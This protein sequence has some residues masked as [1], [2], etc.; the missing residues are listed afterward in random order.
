[1]TS[2]STVT[3]MLWQLPATKML[4]LTS[5]VTG[6]SHI[7]FS[8]QGDPIDTNFN[9]LHIDFNGRKTHCLHHML[10]QVEL[11]QRLEGVSR[12]VRHALLTTNC[13]SSP[14]QR[15]SCLYSFWC[16]FHS[17]Q[18]HNYVIILNFVG[19]FLKKNPVDCTRQLCEESPKIFRKIRK[20]P[21]FF[22]NFIYFT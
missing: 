20:I 15:Y 17:I 14:D 21:Y 2:Y 22:L 16:I 19:Y 4:I 12:P 10:S 13:K 11:D 9:V 6:C 18:Q 5:Q 8:F 1:M 3:K 7:A